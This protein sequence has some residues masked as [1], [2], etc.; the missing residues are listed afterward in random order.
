[1]SPVFEINYG[2]Y[3]ILNRINDDT[4]CFDMAL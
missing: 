3:E 2:V 4:L 1:M